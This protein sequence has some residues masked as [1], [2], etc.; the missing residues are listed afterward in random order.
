MKRDIE[1]EKR[2]DKKRNEKCRKKIGKEEI[3][4]R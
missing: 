3:K 4:V 1:S 2:A